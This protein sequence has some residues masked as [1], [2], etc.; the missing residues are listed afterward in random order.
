M[1]KINKFIEET[2][3]LE[4]KNNLNP[5]NIFKKIALIGKTALFFH[6]CFY[7]KNWYHVVALNAIAF[8][9]WDWK[10][11]KTPFNLNY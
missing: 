9:N 3:T 4:G 8:D 1:R 5:N 6:P 7:E 2:K 11:K 10:L